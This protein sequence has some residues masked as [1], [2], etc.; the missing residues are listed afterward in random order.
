MTLTPTHSSQVLTATVIAG[1]DG[2]VL[3]TTLLPDGR[4]LVGG[5]FTTYNRVACGK[6][7]RLNTDGTLDTSFAMDGTGL[8]GSVRT[9]VVEPIAARPNNPK[10]LAGGNFTRYNGANCAPVVR[11]HTNGRRDVSFNIASSDLSGTIN[12]IA[13]QPDSLILVGGYS[14]PDIVTRLSKTG[15]REQNFQTNFTIYTN[16]YVTGLAVLP[17]QD[18]LVAGLLTIRATA[19]T[20]SYGYTLAVIR[21]TT[22]LSFGVDF[23]R[24]FALPGDSDGP[25][26]LIV[27]KSFGAQITAPIGATALTVKGDSILVARYATFPSSGSAPFVGQFNYVYHFSVAGVQRGSYNTGGGTVS[28]LGFHRN[29]KIL[30]GGSFTPSGGTAPTYLARLNAN[31]TRDNT[32]PSSVPNGQVRALAVQADAK[33]I[34][35]GDFTSVGSA[36]SDRSARLTPTGAL[37]P[38]TGV[39]VSGATYS[40]SRNGSLLTATA[41]PLRVTTSGIYTATATIGSQSATSNAVTVVDTRRLIIEPSTAASTAAR[42]TFNTIIVKAGGVG[43]L[44]GN[45]TIYDTV[46]VKRG[47]TLRLGANLVMSGASSSKFMIEPGATLS[48]GDPAGITTSGQTGAVRTA[49]RSF[50]DSSS[51]VYTGIGTQVTGNALP[52]LVRNLTDSTTQAGATLSLSR[53]ISVSQVLTIAS[54]NDFNLNNQPLRLPSSASGT[55]LVVNSS[56]GGAAGGTATMERY[57]DQTFN[58]GRGARYYSSPVSG[59]TVGSFAAMPTFVNASTYDPTRLN[60]ATATISSGLAPVATNASLAVGQ[61]YAVNIAA[62]D[63]VSF[64]GALTSGPQTLALTRTNTGQIPRASNAGWNLVGNPYPSPL[65]WSRV[66]GADRPNLDAAIY[67]Y[68]STGPTTG[69]YTTY[70]N[71]WGDTPIIAAGQSFFVRVSDN[72]SSASLALDN[73]QRVTSYASQAAF[74][75]FSS[76]GNGVALSFSRPPGGTGGGKPPTVIYE[77]ALAV[78]NAAGFSPNTDAYRIPSTDSLSLSISAPAPEDELSIKALRTIPTNATTRI[79]LTARVL[80][81]GNYT[82]QPIIVQVPTGLSAFLDDDSTGTSVNLSRPPAT[83]PNYAFRRANVP[84]TGRFVLRFGPTVATATNA[85]QALRG[86]ALY[87]NPAHSQVVVQVPAVPGASQLRAT[88]LNELG[89]VV[90]RQDAPLA[91]AGTRMLLNVQGL[92]PG[93]YAVRLQTGSASVV[94]RLIIE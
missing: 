31:A 34:I 63:K 82:I 4:V 5:A 49:T 78:P 55:A 33:V 59:A 74:N 62:S 79:P 11:L 86:I 9:I 51:Y 75:R 22:N 20:D 17:N 28:A 27:A 90:G 46:L 35:G 38:T 72:Q 47:G 80:K 64:S 91:A 65:D 58:P 24:G 76:N 66:T 81:R 87:P 37:D 8:D 68:V 85:Q 16:S 84:I 60:T 56:T 92:A 42:D 77:D 1:F 48:V 43:K 50:A 15:V 2:A 6:I 73:R 94:Q 70:V 61:G 36:L 30:L 57:I 26:P 25:S 29:G 67:T 21:P 71:G 19:F 32:F 83:W 44:T 10:I 39:L 41:N 3:A 7:V 12:A 54:A 69:F 93:V 52:A 40:W 89:Q 45:V 53:A 23:V 18:I 14:S 13:V 88:L